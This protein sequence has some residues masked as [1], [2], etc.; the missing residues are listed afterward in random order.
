MESLFLVWFNLDKRHIKRKL[1]ASHNR[2]EDAG[3]VEGSFFIIRA[4][5]YIAI[6]GFDERTFLYAE[7]II[8]ARR[9]KAAGQK[10]EY[11]QGS[12]MTTF[13]QPV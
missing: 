3:V 8:L 12:D 10:V 7:E 6:E 13:I 5:D 2:I 1:T 11:L 9:L 4:K